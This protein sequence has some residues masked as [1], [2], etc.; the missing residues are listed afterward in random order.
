M[1]AMADAPFQSHPVHADQEGGVEAGIEMIRPKTAALSPWR[2]NKPAHLQLLWS[3]WTCCRRGNGDR[4][5][6][7]HPISES[8]P[9]VVADASPR[10]PRLADLAEQVMESVSEE[11]CGQDKAAARREPPLGTTCLRP[12]VARVT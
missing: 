6:D 3:M 2:S 11:E 8:G 10:P 12:R 7:T 1:M 4:R 9:E 5:D